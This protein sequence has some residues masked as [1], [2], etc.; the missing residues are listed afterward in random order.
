MT[1]KITVAFL[2]VLFVTAFLGA[3]SVFAGGQKESKAAAK[4]AAT[5]PALKVGMVADVGG[6]N[7]HSFNQLTYRGLL[8]A[9]KQLGVKGT[10][11]VARGQSDYVPDMTRFAQGGYDLVIGVGFLMQDA[12][13]KVSKEYPQVKFLL[14][15]QPVGGRP[16]VTSAV[17]ASQQIGFLAGALAALIEQDKSLDLPGLRHNNTVGVVGG[18]Q[19]PPVD[20]YMAGYFQGVHYI[21]PTITVLHGYTGN[22]N[23][24]ASGKSLALAQHSKGADIVYQLAG[25]TGLGVIQAAKDGGFYAIGADSNQAYLAP[26]HVLTSTSKLVNVAV[27]DTIKKLQSGQF[28]PGVVTYNLQNRGVDISPILKSVPESIVAKVEALKQKII[29]G[30]ITVSPKIPA[31]VN[32]RK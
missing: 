22:F 1:K 12:I 32:S 25:G 4:P 26:K 20:V 9:E 2:S 28:E 27:F 19:I 18:M 24:P 30:G 6:L 10:A 3:A 31:W 16:N 7:D 13:V 14:I 17:F 15:D 5:K 11:V 8:D 23:D 29:D 21:D